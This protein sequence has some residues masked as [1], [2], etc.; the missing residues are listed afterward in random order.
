MR[1]FYL[2]TLML[3]PLSVLAQASGSA[4]I[5]DSQ[6]K[7]ISEYVDAYARNP[8]RKNTQL[9]IDSLPEQ[10]TVFSDSAEETRANDIVYSERVMTTLELQ[11]RKKDPESVRLAF[12]MMNIADGAFAEDLDTLVGKLIRID[13]ILFLSELKFSGRVDLVGLVGNLGDSFS[14]KFPQ[15]CSELNQRR[16]ALKKIRTPE[17]QSVKQRAEKALSRA[18]VETPACK[19]T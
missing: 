7:R 16:R 1:F 10:Q 2:L 19:S 8:S 15:Q 14:D 3:L 5:S 6:W 18:I 12:K 11:V 13:P 4:P 9:A 17:L